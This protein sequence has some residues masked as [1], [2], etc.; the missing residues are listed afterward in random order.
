M[1]YHQ[2]KDI[3]H[4]MRFLGHRSIKNTLVYIDLETACHPNGGD[5]FADGDV[6]HLERFAEEVL[7]HFEAQGTQELLL[8]GESSAWFYV[9]TDATDYTG[10]LATVQ[11]SGS[12]AGGIPVLVPLPEPATLGLVGLGGMGLLLWRKRRRP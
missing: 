6:L 3:L 4:V 1:L 9:E 7:F 2:T 12:S 8:P 11:D 5:D 10:G